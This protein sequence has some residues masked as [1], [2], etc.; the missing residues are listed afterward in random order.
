[1]SFG[2]RPEVVAG[3]SMLEP[4]QFVLLKRPQ[5]AH[6]SQAQVD[7][8]WQALHY[9]AR[10]D[11]AQVC[12]EFAAF[13]ALLADFGAQIGYLPPAG[14]TGLDSIY[15]HDPAVITDRGAVLCQMGKAA[16]RAEPQAM[17]EYLQ[18]IGVPLLGQI[19]PPGR[20]EGGDVLWLDGSTL[21]VGL[22]Y[23]TNA[24]GLAQLQAFLGQAVTVIP[25]PLPHWTGPA[26][27]LHLQSF[28]SLVD[29]RTAV[30][31]SRLMPVP[32]RQWLLEGGWQLLE[33]PDEEYE[34]FA[35]NVLALAP[36][37]CVMIAGNPRTQSQLEAAGV[38]VRTFP[39]AD[40]CIKGGGGPTCLTRPITRKTQ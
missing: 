36:G 1:M 19:Q 38:Q 5:E 3:Q 7:A 39:G 13:E 15:T 31:Y 2:A 18:E 12:R 25:V 14:A 29:R 17:G 20:L 35:G 24:A 9:P 16:R 11:F 30:V 26:D 23:R 37:R 28:I 40:L 33:V 21:A 34:T 22:G 32:F 6:G 8:Q 27:C 4:L 10:P